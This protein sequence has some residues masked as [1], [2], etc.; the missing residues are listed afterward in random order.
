MLKL[1]A[2]AMPIVFPKWSDRV[3]IRSADETAVALDQLAV[4]TLLGRFLHT[5]RVGS[6]AC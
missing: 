2:V 1:A 3:A 4:V 6:S 5:G